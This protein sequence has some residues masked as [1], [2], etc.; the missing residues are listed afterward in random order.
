M[1][2]AIRQRPQHEIIVVLGADKHV[3]SLFQEPGEQHLAHDLLAL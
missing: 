1:Q 3:P 2:G